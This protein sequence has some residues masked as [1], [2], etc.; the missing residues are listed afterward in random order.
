MAE[1]RCAYFGKCGGCS[2]QHIDY[3]IQVEN[4]KKQLARATGTTPEAFTGKLYNYRTRMDFIFCKEGLGFRKHKKPAEIVHTDNCTIANDGVNRIAIEVA[5]E[6]KDID[7][8]DFKNYKG[9]YKYAVIR[10]P[11]GDSSL[12]FV[13]NQDS[14]RLNE[15]VEKI[16][17][18][19]SSARNI[20]I[21]YVAH[22]TNVSVSE[23][24]FIVKGKDNLCEDLLGKKFQYPIQGFFQ[25]NHELAELM[26]KYVRGI[27][28]KQN[29]MDYEL[30]DMYSGVGTFGIINADLFKKVTMIESY[31]KSADFANKNILANN[32]QNA[33]SHALESKQMKRLKLARQL[34]IITD[35]PRT[36]MD[37]ET[38]AQI[39]QLSPEKIIYIS[40]NADQLAKDIKKFKNYIAG[41]AGL[42]DLFPHTPHSESIVELNKDG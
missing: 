29:T 7:F 1:P 41:K 6:F 3:E 26:H 20:I 19:A 25:N 32:A 17:N 11:P 39:N 14:N 38:I 28:E 4:K 40:C 21:A 24:Y 8:F 13:L 23:D 2:S 36:G 10:A 15:A 12:S 33:A 42:F 22:S 27:L 18:F 30:L 16:K 9:T 31:K 37:N 5:K 35:P 34:I